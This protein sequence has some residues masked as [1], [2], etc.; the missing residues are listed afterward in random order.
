VF[1]SPQLCSTLRD[2]NR[3]GDPRYVAEPKFDG[4][5]AQVHIVAGRTVAAYSRR[6]LSLLRHPG[7]AWLRDVRWPIEQAVLDGEVC[8][9]T[10][11]DGIQAVLENVRK[12]FLERREL[13]AIVD[14]LPEDLKAVFQVAYISGW[15]VKSELLTR[16]RSHVDLVHG[17]L[18]LEPG[19]SKNEEGRQFPVTPELREVLVRQLERTRDIEK[20]TGQVIPWLFHRNGKP[21]K[22]FRRAWQTACTRAGVPKRIPHDFR[23]TAVRNLERAGVSR[24][25]AMKMVGHKTQ[26][27]Y[28]SYA[29]A[30]ESMLQDGGAKL[31]ALHAKE[32]EA[33]RVLVPITAAQSHSGKVRTKSGGQPS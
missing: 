1:I 18:R 7:L 20:A 12:G 31:S 8:G 6:G 9:A 19:E 28:S 13:Q 33:A 21:I 15:R 32:A 24:S 10:G 27:I 16:Q 2:P 4:Q 25:A 23:R 22:S 5:R 11:S 3:L 26:S 29:I 14:L 30:D 17:W